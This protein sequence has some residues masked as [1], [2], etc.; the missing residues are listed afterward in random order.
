[1]LLLKD[2]NGIVPK[3]SIHGLA[4]TANV[5]PE[6]CQAALDKFLAP[7]AKSGSQVEE[8]RRIRDTPDGWQIINHEEYQF[9][10]EAKRLAWAEHKQM[11]RERE[12]EKQRDRKE[13]KNRMLKQMKGG[14]LGGESAF[15]E[16][17]GNGD[18]KTADAIIDAHN[19][20]VGA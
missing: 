16:A 5:L 3:S 8:G 13:K 1:M 4:H 10:T 17:E 6:E 11:Q 7:D 14:P 9:S 2:K 19:R 18:Y 12:R 15:V 20:E